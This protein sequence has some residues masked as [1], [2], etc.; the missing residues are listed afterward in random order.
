[1]VSISKLSYTLRNTEN[2]FKDIH[3]N[4]VESSY[5]RAKHNIRSGFKI[6]G[7]CFDDESKRSIYE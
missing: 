2:R 6:V 5:K 4:Y 3:A 1:M 7:V